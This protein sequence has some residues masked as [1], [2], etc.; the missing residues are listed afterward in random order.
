MVIIIIGPMGCGKSTI[1][2]LLAEKLGYHFD[3]AD[4]FHPVENIEKMRAGI[5]L[6]DSDRIGWLTILA[7]RIQNRVD[8]HQNLVMAC[9]ALKQSYRQ[10]LGINQQQ[11][12][13]IY[14]K[15]SYHLLHERLRLRT[16]QYM[17]DALLAS[18]LAT[19]EEPS[20][21]LTIDIS[22]SPAAIVEQ[23]ISEMKLEA[24]N[25]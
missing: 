14:L 9:S 17:N 6:Q 1:G 8:H 24:S 23:I 15:G 22:P 11:V 3:D 19:M 13:S 10:Q 12:K 20:D 21:G 7:K 18:Q 16:H 25:D 5:A 2:R 4:D